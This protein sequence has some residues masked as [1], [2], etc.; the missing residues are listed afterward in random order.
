M[1]DFNLVI[2]SK[3]EI[4]QQFL[5]RQLFYVLTQIRANH[6]LFKRKHLDRNIPQILYTCIQRR[7]I[8]IPLMIRMMMI[9]KLT[10]VILVRKI[11]NIMLPQTKPVQHTEIETLFILNTICIQM[12]TVMIHLRTN[13]NAQL[14]LTQA[15]ELKS[16]IF[17]Q[18][19]NHRIQLE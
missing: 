17:L 1:R 19:W 15:I 10:I 11:C 8:R 16:M 14:K 6:L 12:E 3:I 7:R 13:F 4:M 5:T 9:Q 18:R 2:C